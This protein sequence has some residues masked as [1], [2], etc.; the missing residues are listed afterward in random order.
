MVRGWPKGWIDEAL[1]GLEGL[2]KWERGCNPGPGP[3]LSMLRNVR[4]WP[5]F[6]FRFRHSSQNAPLRIIKLAARGPCALLLLYVFY[7]IFRRLLL[8][9]ER[10][11]LMTLPSS[12]IQSEVS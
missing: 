3:F 10:V 2:S 11:L 12:I 9:S 1:R 8:V 4:R 7:S 5:C 6:R